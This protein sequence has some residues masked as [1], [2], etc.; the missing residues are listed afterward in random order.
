MILGYTKVFRHDTKSTSDKKN[1]KLDLIITIFFYF[2]RYYPESEMS[3]QTLG[4]YTYKSFI[5]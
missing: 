2:K 1:D 3:P 4:E 5:L